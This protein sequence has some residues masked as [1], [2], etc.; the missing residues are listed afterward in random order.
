MTTHVLL[1]EVRAA[2]AAKDVVEAGKVAAEARWLA[3]VRAVFSERVDRTE[4]AHAAGFAGR[5]GL[6]KLLRRNA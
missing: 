1:V 2:T 5:D 4:L 6:Y 3:V